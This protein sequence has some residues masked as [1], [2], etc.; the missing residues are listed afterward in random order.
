MNRQ[1]FLSIA[2]A[3]ATGVGAFA[4]LAPTALLASKGVV[5][6]AT[7]VW[8]QEVGI[9]LLAVGLMA[10]LARNAPDSAAL[11]A[12]LVGNTV[13]QLGLLPI[14]IMAYHHGVISVLSGIVPNSILHG[15]LALGFAYF[16][17]TMKPER[18]W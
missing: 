10:F 4:L 6:L 3:I 7:E 11:R 1:I 13:I 8:V 12:L 15:L 16:A 17:V 9:F 5:G 14:E 2:A 18:R